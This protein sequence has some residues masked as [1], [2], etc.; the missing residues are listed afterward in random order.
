MDIET[1]KGLLIWMLEGDTGISSKTIVRIAIGVKPAK[2][3]Y[4]DAPYDPS[5]FGRCYRL[6]K[7][8]PELQ[9]KLPLVAKKCKAFAPLIANWDELVQL[10]EEES[11]NKTGRA[12]KLYARMKQLRGRE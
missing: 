2:G 9:K 6:L 5:D 8:F 10:W 7:K 12:P 1:T 4:F 3:D 11:K